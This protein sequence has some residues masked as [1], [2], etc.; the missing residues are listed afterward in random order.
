MPHSAL[1]FLG[2]E[3]FR[4][5][6]LSI[7]PDPSPDITSA[8]LDK[9]KMDSLKCS[10]LHTLSIDDKHE[11]AKPERL[12]MCVLVGRAFHYSISVVNSTIPLHHSIPLNPDA[13]FSY[14]IIILRIISPGI[15]LEDGEHMDFPNL[16]LMSPPWNFYSRE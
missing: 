3:S 12:C 15:C 9:M 4:T 8:V 7:V 13:P 6:G 16:R 5:V 14:P 1:F 2:G 10:I 11:A